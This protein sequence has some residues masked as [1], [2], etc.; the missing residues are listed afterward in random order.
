MLLH[1]DR[2]TVVGRNASVGFVNDSDLSAW[3][4]VAAACFAVVA[5]FFTARQI[6]HQ[7][8]Q[9]KYQAQQTQHQVRDQLLHAGAFYI[10]RYWAIDDDL[11]FTNEGD[12]DH[13]R[14]EFRYLRLC[15]DELEAA[16]HEW[17]DRSQWKVW[18]DEVFGTEEFA[19]LTS[20]RLVSCRSTPGEN[21]FQLLRLCTTQTRDRGAHTWESCQAASTRPESSASMSARGSDGVNRPLSGEV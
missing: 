1:R 19:A 15:E 10:E 16:R 8:E 7:A 14:H 9:T 6:R 5:L 3:A 17:L 13:A 4:T 21:D 20:K 18:H 12:D 11:L 2:L